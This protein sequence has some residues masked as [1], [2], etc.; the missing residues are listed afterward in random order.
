MNW[1]V[2]REE[3]QEAENTISYLIVIILPSSREGSFQE[4]IWNMVLTGATCHLKDTR[5]RAHRDDSLPV[6]L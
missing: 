2:H 6:Q 3:G 5:G 4:S 1:D